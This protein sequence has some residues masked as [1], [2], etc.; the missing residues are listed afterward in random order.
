MRLYETRVVYAHGS[1]FVVRRVPNV[2]RAEGRTEY[3]YDYR[4]GRQIAAGVRYVDGRV[5][6]RL[7][8]YTLHGPNGEFARLHYKQ[9]RKW[10]T[11]FALQALRNGV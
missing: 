1:R 3:A 8:P 9:L 2:V 5:V 7:P 4:H 11:Y 6:D 10:I